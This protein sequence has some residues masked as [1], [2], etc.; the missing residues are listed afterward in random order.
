MLCFN[1][2]LL[3]K[4]CSGYKQLFCRRAKIRSA[5][6]KRGTAVPFQRALNE[7]GNGKDVTQ[8]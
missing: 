1:W 8:K 7:I 4:N 3:C 6:A 5:I 2:L